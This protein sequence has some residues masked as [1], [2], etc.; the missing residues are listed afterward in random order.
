MNLS[1][2][3]PALSKTVEE[4]WNNEI[5]GNYEKDKSSYDSNKFP[6]WKDLKDFKDLL[7]KLKS[8]YSKQYYDL[9]EENPSPDKYASVIF[10]SLLK[11]EGLD[12]TQIYKLA[13][14]N[15]EDKF[16]LYYDISMYLDYL[17]FKK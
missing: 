17:D 6:R 13:S 15:Q 10:L 8:C 2:Q 1:N 5:K 4:F 3:I 7:E 11:K 9:K 12:I 16:S 14:H